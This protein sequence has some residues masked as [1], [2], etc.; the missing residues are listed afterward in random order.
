MSASAYTGAT[1]FFTVNLLQ[2][3]ANSLLVDRIDDLRN[4][5]RH[6]KATWPL[7]I[8]AMVVLPEHLHA[9]W[10]LPPGDKSLG[11]RWGLIKSRFSRAIPTGEFLRESRVPRGERGIWQR[12]FWEHQIRD[13]ADLAAQIDYIHYNPVPDS[14]QSS[15]EL[16]SPPGKRL[17]PMS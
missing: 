4:S 13:E 8:D 11:L 12:R 6:V 9:I 17:G 7:R 2:R 16:R 3:R 10:T 1:W 5:I 14:Y 15:S